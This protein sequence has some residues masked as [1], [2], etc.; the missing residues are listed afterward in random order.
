MSRAT[1]ERLWTVEDLYT[2]PD[3]GLK[4]ELEAGVLVSEPLPGFRHGLVMTTVSRL[5]DTYVRAHRL[6]VVL[7][8]DSGFV[9]ARRPDTVRGPDVAFIAE[10]RLTAVDDPALAYPGPP[11]LAVEVLSP[12]NRQA[13]IRAKVADYLAAGTRLVWVLDPERETVAVYRTLLAPRLL[14]SED[15]LDGEDVVPSFRTSVAA[16]FE[17]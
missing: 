4:H 8:G 10:A 15:D 12:G 13:A 5:L 3:D 9:L 6:G 11:D 14:S 17:F 7:T 1:P 2:L 16:L